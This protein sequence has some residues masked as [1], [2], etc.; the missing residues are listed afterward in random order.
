M[1]G[2]ADPFDVLAKHLLGVHLATGSRSPQSTYYWRKK[3]GLVGSRRQPNRQ[4]RLH[5]MT[6]EQREAHIKECGRQ[7]IQAYEAGDREKAMYWL[8][9]EITTIKARSPA[10]IARMEGCFFDMQGEADA[11]ALAG[12]AHA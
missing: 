1:T 8:Q 10:Q 4:W 7:M 5:I 9:A 2:Q 11:L 12:V 3:A 6:D